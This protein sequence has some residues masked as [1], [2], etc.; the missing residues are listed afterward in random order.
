[1]TRE[2]IEMA[3]SNDGIRVVR[4]SFWVGNR[5]MKRGAT[6][7]AS[8]PFIKKYERNFFPVDYVDFEWPERK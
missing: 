3:A 4:Q 1:M 7:R 6:V 8:H 2:G 5:L